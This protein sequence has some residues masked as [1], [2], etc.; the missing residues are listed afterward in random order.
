[1]HHPPLVWQSYGGVQS[2]SWRIENAILTLLAV[3]LSPS[4]VQHASKIRDQL[5]GG[6]LVHQSSSP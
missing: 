5:G 4:Q 3:L 1:M 2:L 6:C